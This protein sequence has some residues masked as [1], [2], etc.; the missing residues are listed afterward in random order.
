[1]IKILFATFFIAELII[2]FTVISKIHNLNKCVNNLNAS[3]LVN[4]YKIKM[5]INDFRLFIE[6][7][8]KNLGILSHFVRKKRREYFVS[9]LKNVTIY[10]SIFF[11]KGKYKKTILAYQLASEIYEGWKEVQI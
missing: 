9:F 6:D 10:M 2:A 3:I 5:R 8:V 11:L 4:R 7:F 1:M